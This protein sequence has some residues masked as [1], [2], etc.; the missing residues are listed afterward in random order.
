MPFHINVTVT[1]LLICQNICKKKKN[2]DIYILY[3]Y[4]IGLQIFRYLCMWIDNSDLV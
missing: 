1:D 2:T 3:Y 4:Q